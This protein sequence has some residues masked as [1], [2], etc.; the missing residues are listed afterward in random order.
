MAEALQH[1]LLS[2]CL[3]NVNTELPR[4]TYWVCRCLWLCSSCV[5]GSV[6][7]GPEGPGTPGS[8]PSREAGPSAGT[9]GT[10]PTWWPAAHSDSWTLESS[11]DHLSPSIITLSSGNFTAVKAFSVK[12][13]TT[14]SKFNSMHNLLQM[15]R[16]LFT[17]F[18]VYLPQ[19]STINITLTLTII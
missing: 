17:Y 8:G 3:L 10:C 4:S 7:P 14:K 18:F 12:T 5:V 13:K 9:P 16:C 1:R 19:G 2:G 15:L 6:G 11:K